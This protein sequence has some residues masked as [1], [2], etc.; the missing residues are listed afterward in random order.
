[1]DIVPIRI[2]A[3][4]LSLE[5]LLE[6]QD[7]ILLADAQVDVRGVDKFVRAR[8]DDLWHVL[9]WREHAIAAELRAKLRLGLLF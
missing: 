6:W 2:C 5:N 8:C 3:P 9:P 1:M 7:P 4:F